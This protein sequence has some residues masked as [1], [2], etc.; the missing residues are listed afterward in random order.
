MNDPQAIL[1]SGMPLK[2]RFRRKG[3]QPLMDYIK[4]KESE[5]EHFR[6][7][8]DLQSEIDTPAESSAYIFSNGDEP[9]PWFYDEM[10]D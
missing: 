9:E 5:S 4:S 8:T 10:E 1:D 6:N 7:S 2:S 3:M